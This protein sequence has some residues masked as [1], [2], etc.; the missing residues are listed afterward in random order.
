MPHRHPRTRHARR[1]LRTASAPETDHL[2]EVVPV[3]ADDAT[4]VVSGTK[5]AEEIGI[6]RSAVWRSVEHLREL[7]VAI[8]GHPR[9]GSQLDRAPDGGDCAIPSAPVLPT[10]LPC[11][12]APPA[13]RKARC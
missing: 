12:P 4:V 11:R 13:N 6:S 3:L 9:T 10:R 1:P 2:A 8:A 7:G 5:L